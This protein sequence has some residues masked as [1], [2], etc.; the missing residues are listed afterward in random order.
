MVRPDGVGPVKV[1]MT[2]DQ[3]NMTL[4]EHFRMPV[5]NEDLGCFYVKPK[6]HPTLAFMIEDGHFVRVDVDEPGIATEKAVRVGDSED[7]IKRAYG[8]EVNVEPSKYTG[9]E[10]GHYLTV[11]STDGKYGIRF[12]TEKRKITELYAGTY[13]TIQY[14]EGCE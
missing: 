3:L 2:L 1:G 4:H 7:Q 11:R 9:D 8:A 14:I 10:G 5:N 12:E 6:S 13:K